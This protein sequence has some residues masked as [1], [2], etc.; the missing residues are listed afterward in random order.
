MEIDPLVGV[1]SEPRLGRGATASRPALNVPPPA[2]RAASPRAPE[3]AALQRILQ[4][5][6]L[7]PSAENKHHLAFRVQAAAVELL[8]TDHA[9]WAEQPHRRMLALLA[10]GAVI[11]NIALESSA[12][13]WALTLCAGADAERDD[14]VTTLRWTPSS[15]R[16]DPLAQRIA[17]RHTNRRFYPRQKLD[18]P[19]IS[20]LTDA[21]RAVA[22][23]NVLWLDGPAERRTALAAM[24]IAEAERFRRKGLH[25]ELFESVRFEAG[26]SASTDEWLSPSA[27]QIERPMRRAFA[28]LRHWPLMRA[29]HVIGAHHVLGLRAGYLPSAS[30]PHIGLIIGEAGGV[31]DAATLLAAGRSFQRLWLAADAEGLALQ[32]MAAATVLAGQRAGLEWVS[33]RTQATL[34]RLLGKLVG[35][36]PARPYMLFRLGRAAPPTARALRKPLESYLLRD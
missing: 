13:G 3:E 6:I 1:R 15:D 24:R 33:A 10:F 27:L 31:D 21:A 19:S 18:A 20:H 5:G 9:S 12:A 2:T 7:A 8:S 25:G 22:G 17:S 34:R 23:C 35:E 26:W 30:S 28:L 32:P 16:A 36:G 4:A 11:E 14:L 29:A